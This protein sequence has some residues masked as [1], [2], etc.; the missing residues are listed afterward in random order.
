MYRVLI[1]DD[2]PEIRHGLRLKVD[3]E[4]LGLSIAGE[5]ENG[6]EA[7]ARLETEAFDILVTD[8]NMPVMDGTVLL[9]AC[10]ELY[11][12]LRLIVLSGYE[13]FRY[14]KAAVK[15]RA[16]DYLL[17]PVAR[18]E[19]I[20]VL[21]KLKQELDAE[22]ASQDEQTALRR[23]LS[24]AYSGHTQRDRQRQ[25][26]SDDDPE[27]TVLQ[28]ACRYIDEHYMY[29]LN[30]T[31]MAQRYKYHPTYFS[32]RFKAQSG[33]TFI[34]YLTDVRMSHAVR[35]LKDT[36]LNLWDIAELTGF[37]NASYFSSKFKKVY[38]LTPS[39]YRQQKAPEKI[40][41]ED[42]KK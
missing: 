42:P 26:G 34:Q 37:S 24:P 27:R 22:R 6:S 18:D 1:V 20:Q 35:L 29:D 39:D 15:S 11:P 17:K 2:E 14:T 19:L 12:S 40:D 7:L 30:L 9:D 23:R 21:T 3:W 32:E 38:G 28:A 41:S 31:Q 36:A 13:D 8:M 33:K 25:K 5:A 16:R 4:A 10:S